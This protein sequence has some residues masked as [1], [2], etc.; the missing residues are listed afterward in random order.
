MLSLWVRD[1]NRNIGKRNVHLVKSGTTL[2]LGGGRSDFLVFLV[3]LPHRIADI[4]FDGEYCSLVP[5]RPD[6]FPDIGS[7]IVD[8]CLGKDI[9]VLSDKGYELYLRIEKFEDPLLK[10][11]AFLHS[12]D[13]AGRE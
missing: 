1:Q 9:R 3:P 10:L 5:R 7:T 6:Y 13:T 8:D 11:N 12:I 4:H 2:S